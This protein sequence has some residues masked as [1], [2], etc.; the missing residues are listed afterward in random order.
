MSQYKR[1]TIPSLSKEAT[2][3][4]EVL[5]SKARP[6]SQCVVE[7]QITAGLPAMPYENQWTRQSPSQYVVEDQ[8][9]AGLP[10]MPY[11]NQWAQQERQVDALDN[12][13]P[14]TIPFTPRPAQSS[15]H[16]GSNGH[17]HNHQVGA[18]FTIPFT[19]RP[20]QSNGHSNGHNGYANGHDRHVDAI[21]AFLT[22]PFTPRP[23]Q[24]SRHNGSN[25][26]SNVA[27]QT[28]AIPFES[29]PQ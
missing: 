15:R 25:G 5:F 17:A 3:H 13:P 16:N 27:F 29:D 22:I 11:E 19:P 18:F 26:S 14:G 23:A 9:T 20:A 10:A 1:L 7:D 28:T 8:I 2:L 4:K 12:F 24:S 6:V 21:D